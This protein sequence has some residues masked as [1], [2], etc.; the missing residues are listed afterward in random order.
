MEKITKIVS[1][2]LIIVFY[3]TVLSSHM[4]AGGV[5]ITIPDYV[6]ITDKWI[7]LGS[8]AII[9][10]TADNIDLD[11]LKSLKLGSSLFPG[12]EKEIPREQVILVIEGSGFSLAD[13]ELNMP[14]KVKI[15]TASKKISGS[16]LVAKVKEYLYQQLNYNP[17][18]LKIT[19]IFEPADLII[20]DEEYF[21]EYN[22]SSPGKIPGNLS[23]AVNVKMGNK[24]YRKLYVNFKVQVIQ[25]V[26]VANRTI[27][28]GEKIVSSDFSKERQTISM[29]RGNIIN[30]LDTTLVKYGIVKKNIPEN[31]V[32]T[33]YYLALPEIIAKGDQLSAEVV[34]GNVHVTT[35]VKACQDGSKGD[36]IL[37]ENLKSGRKF[38]AEV[39]SPLLVR[40]VR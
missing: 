25:T 18:D 4:L 9:E 8:I 1:C 36:F 38:R 21:L 17:E 37:V 11:K 32:L 39:I 12:Y 14:N 13:I 6:E 27:L 23:V 31:S 7:Y 22:L 2:I 5:I 24:V 35:I 3:L 40:V 29:T 15:R 34:S 20:P 30:D 28:A 33:D 10:G 16:K 26:F 19:P